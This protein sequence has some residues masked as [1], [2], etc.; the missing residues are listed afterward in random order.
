MEIR[1]FGASLTEIIKL[2]KKLK[3]NDDDID[4]VYIAEGSAKIYHNRST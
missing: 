1:K 4:T 3:Q 2:T